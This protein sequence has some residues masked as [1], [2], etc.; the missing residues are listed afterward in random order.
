M[1]SAAI[2]AEKNKSIAGDLWHINDN[3][4]FIES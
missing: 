4:S 1:L 2:M 3:F